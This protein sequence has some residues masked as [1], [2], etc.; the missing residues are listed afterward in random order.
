MEYS[1]SQRDPPRASSHFLRPSLTW[2]ALYIIQLAFPG[3]C[4]VTRCPLQCAVTFITCW[5]F[6]ISCVNWNKEQ[7]G[8][9]NIVSTTKNAIPSLHVY[10]F[11]V[12]N[13]TDAFLPYNVTSK[14]DHPDPKVVFTTLTSWPCSNMSNSLVIHCRNC[15]LLFLTF[16]FYI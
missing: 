14:K 15:H 7:G 2:L 6:T 10:T 1:S 8:E 4:L 3:S 13:F 9:G 16:F 12:S 5:P 11:L